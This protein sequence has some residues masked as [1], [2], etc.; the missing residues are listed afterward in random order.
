ML[1]GAIVAIDFA[2]GYY[3]IGAEFA[4]TGTVGATL[5][6]NPIHLRHKSLACEMDCNMTRQ[7]L[8]WLA[9]ITCLLLFNNVLAQ[10]GDT[11]G[12]VSI[13]GASLNDDCTTLSVD[14]TVSGDIPYVRVQLALYSSPM[15]LLV[16]AILPAAGGAFA[17][18]DMELY[19][20]LEY[21]SLLVM[22]TGWDGSDYITALQSDGIRSVYCTLDVNA[23]YQS[24]VPGLRYMR[25]SRQIWT[26]YATFSAE[27]SSLDSE[28]CVE[29]LQSEETSFPSTLMQGQDEESSFPLTL[30]I[31]EN[32]FLLRFDWQRRRFYV[33]DDGGVFYGQYVERGDDDESDED[34]TYYA[35]DVWFTSLTTYTGYILIQHPSGCHWAFD[36]HGERTPN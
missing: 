14:G 32:G 31:A 21:T 15:V 10:E 6:L 24:R 26:T 23:G 34:D 22:V 13:G 12:P 3:N 33:V 7:A 30:T 17:Q 18:E 4:Y 2:D 19:T 11:R 5:L 29:F 27:S 9:L 35:F 20:A 28:S 1:T 25:S 36:W 16:D 8:R